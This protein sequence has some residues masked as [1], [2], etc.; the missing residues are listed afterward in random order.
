MISFKK[1]EFC[2]TYVT[3]SDKYQIQEVRILFLVKNKF[4]AK[5][6]NS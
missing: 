4:I 3:Y 1:I 2:L 5:L 6:A